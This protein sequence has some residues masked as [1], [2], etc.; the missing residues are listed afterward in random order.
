MRQAIHIFKKDLDY[1]WIEIAVMLALLV[2]LVT[3]ELTRWPDLRPLGLAGGLRALLPALIT[4]GWFV[5]IARVIHAEALV[6]DRQFWLTRPYSR[7]SLG[8]AKAMFALA[9]LGLPLLLAQAA[10]LAGEGFSLQANLAA[11]LRNQTALLTTL[12][13]AA[14]LAAVTAD[15]GKMV[16]GTLLLYVGILVLLTAIGPVS[17]IGV[18]LF[19][20]LLV[21]TSA[22]VVWL[23]YSRRRT[24]VSRL[25]LVASAVLSAAVGAALPFSASSPIERWFSS[26]RFDAAALQIG[27]AHGRLNRVSSDAGARVGVPLRLTGLPANTHVTLNSIQ[28]NIDA[29]DGANWKSSSRA[30]LL[31][32]E[33]P[34][35]PWLILG[36]VP[37]KL[38]QIG[39]QGVTL[40]A[41]LDLTVWLAEEAIPLDSA[42][43]ALE[44][45]GFGKCFFE[46]VPIHCEAPFGPPNREICLRTGPPQSSSTNCWGRNN[47]SFWPEFSI[48]PTTNTLNLSSPIPPNATLVIRA[49][50][51]PRIHKDFELRDLRLADYL[52]QR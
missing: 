23:Q 7:W 6:G 36:V 25:L 20:I 52:I 2:A 5:L 11:L 27:L 9:V 15:L 13:P 4:I 45:M 21:V 41:S 28:V 39:H 14:A 42:G 31:D 24:S 32:S 44:R 49:A 50:E 1:L 22:V 8:A 37:E 29:P 40:R 51:V 19:S 10:I 18:V 12:L 33:R 3:S 46:S 35:E 38:V 48:V 47:S 43:P 30:Y 34:D 16:I 26:G 17:W